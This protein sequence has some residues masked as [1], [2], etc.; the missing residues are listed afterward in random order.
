VSGRDQPAGRRA[1]RKARRVAELSGASGRYG[2]D[3][4]TL[5]L[6]PMPGADRPLKILHVLRSPVGGLFR[7]VIDLARAQAA[8]GHQVGIAADATTGGARADTTLAALSPQL[9]LGLSRVPMSR[10]VG[11]SDLSAQRHVAQRARETDA[12][13]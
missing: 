13:G 12:G 10:H 4:R 6:S 2:P 3:R 9:A 5:V 11:L 1:H 7:H 8:R